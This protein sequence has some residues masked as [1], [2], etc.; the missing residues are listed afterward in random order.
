MSKTKS[1]KSS[2]KL[3]KP[4]K[5]IDTLIPDIYALFEN[6]KDLSDESLGSF[7]QALAKT[8]KDRFKSYGEPE[9]KTLRLS[10][11]GKNPLQ[12]WYDINGT[13]E[14]EKL[15][16]QNRFKFLYGDIIEL[17]VLFLAREAGHSVE[18]EQKEVEVDGVKGHIDGL[19][20]GELIDV[21]SASTF[22]LNKFSD[23]VSLRTS[24]SFGYIE[25]ISGY[26]QALSKDRGYFLAVGKETG[27]M[28]LC[29]VETDDVRPLIK[30]LRNIL[31]SDTPPY[32]CNQDRADGSSGNRVLKSPCTYCKHKDECWKDA[33]NGTGLQRYEYADGIKYF[34]NVAKEPRVNKKES[35]V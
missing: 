32:Q 27:Q 31:E 13:H 24:D 9:R 19:I 20:D 35:N 22:A 18:D 17:L 1:N 21:K 4:T 23:E 11:I 3:S 12:L 5:T 8:L 10:N 34:T 7:T 29:Q 16:G 33:N 30:D 15:T 26:A 2:K 25:Q 6:G 14:T 28:R